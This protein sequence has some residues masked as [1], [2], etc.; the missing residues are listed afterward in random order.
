MDIFQFVEQFSTNEHT[1]AYLRNRGL[2]RQIAPI[3]GR[4]RC[5]RRMTQR[6]ANKQIGK[7]IA[8]P[9]Q[10]VLK[11]FAECQEAIKVVRIE[12]Q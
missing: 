10:I 5:P 7:Q 2:L 9:L 6:R 12:E 11:S 4:N 8:G 1:I 3:C